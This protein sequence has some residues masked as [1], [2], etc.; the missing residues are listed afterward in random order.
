MPIQTSARHLIFAAGL[1]ATVAVVPVFTDADSTSAPRLVAA[2]TTTQSNGSYSLTC[3]PDTAPGLSSG[4][5]P[6][7]QQ[8]TAINQDRS[9]FGL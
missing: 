5:A 6:S 1:V 3:A 8:L 7:E 2:C 4:G 9:R